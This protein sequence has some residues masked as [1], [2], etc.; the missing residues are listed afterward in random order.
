M[1][2]NTKFRYFL[3]EL[4]FDKML[5]SNR[6]LNRNLIVVFELRLQERKSGIKNYKFYIVG[7]KIC[8]AKKTLVLS[9]GCLNPI[10]LYSSCLP[11]VP[12]RPT[13]SY[14]D[15]DPLSFTFASG[16]GLEQ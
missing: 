11:R 13:K 1:N 6:C 12:K 4:L 8:F 9:Q 7:I 3:F 15:L 2:L 10:F 14:F 5:N 16:R